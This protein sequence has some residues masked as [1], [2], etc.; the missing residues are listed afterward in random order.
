MTRDEVRIWLV[1]F[2]LRRVRAD[3]YPSTTQLDL[4]EEIIPCHMLDE[5]LRVLVDKVD[6]DYYPSIP[7]L[8]RMAR[9]IDCLSPR[10]TYG[11]L[12]NSGDL[13]EHQA[14]DGEDKDPDEVEPVPESARS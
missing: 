2:L 13:D 3:R 8:Y 10:L 14:A 1:R 5:Y 9:V 7:L 12:D 11:D 4:I 6:D